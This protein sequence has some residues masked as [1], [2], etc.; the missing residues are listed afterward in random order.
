VDTTAPQTTIDSGPSGT[1]TNRTAT[2]TFS[3]S[4]AGSTFQCQLDTA[5][6]ATCTSPTTHSGLAIGSH[7]FRVRATD[8]AGNTDGTPATRAWTVQRDTTPPQTTITSGPSG[9]VTSQTATFTFSASE[10][11]ATFQCQLDS[12][13]YAACTSPASYE[14]LTNG[15]HV[16]RVRA[17]DRAG[18]TDASPASRTWTV[19][20]DL[21]CGAPMTLIATADA[22]L[23]QNSPTS[24][25]GADS[26]L[27][28]RSKGPAD[29]ARAL[30]R[31]G[32]PTA[33]PDGCVIES[34]TL[35]L[36]SDS[37]KDGRTLQALGVTGD[38]TEGVVTW[39]NQPAT[40][41]AAATTNSGPHWRT[42]DVVAQ[43]QQMATSGNNGFLI[44]DETE[45]QDSEQS[46]HSREKGT[47]VPQLV[48]TYRVAP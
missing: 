23:E 4:E 22:W 32:L 13:A 40:D 12:A 16:F 46:F 38:W 39:G 42:W 8:P 20:A 44:R 27:K 33:P 1:T 3:A 19:E 17:T 25:K 31:F 36:Y 11:G 29:N 43:V 41:G 9:T 7:T 10:T 47:N 45:N 18:N 26:V 24:N 5:P 21:G 28:V 30:L 6:Y 15:T 37:A 14:E 48:I 2:F 34:A 35:R